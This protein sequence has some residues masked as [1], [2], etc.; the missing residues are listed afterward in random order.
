MTARVPFEV[1][2]ERAAEQR[3]QIHESVSELRSA[4][5][6]KMDVKRNA[7]EHLAPVAAVASVLGLAVGWSLAGIFVRD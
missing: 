4:I 2:E 7:R 3:R 1:L 6:H 5:R